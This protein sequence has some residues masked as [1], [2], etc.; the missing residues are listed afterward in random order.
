M[1]PDSKQL[2]S[3]YL[4]FDVIAIIFYCIRTIIWKHK[5]SKPLKYDKNYTW[6]E[7]VL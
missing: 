3:L 5:Y 2:L 1:S 6:F 4:T 7:Y